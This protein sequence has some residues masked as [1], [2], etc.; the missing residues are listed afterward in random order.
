VRLDYQQYTDV[1]DEDVLGET[2]IDRIAFS[3]LYRFKGF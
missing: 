2:N 3:A 1:G